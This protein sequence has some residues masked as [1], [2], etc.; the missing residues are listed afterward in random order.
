MWSIVR[1][2]VCYL[3]KYLSP[4]LNRF[5]DIRVRK[6]SVE[7]TVSYFQSQEVMDV[8]KRPYLETRAYFGLAPFLIKYI[9]HFIFW[10]ILA[11]NVVPE[12]FRYTFIFWFHDRKCFFRDVQFIAVPSL[13]HFANIQFV[14][15]HSQPAAAIMRVMANSPHLLY[16][17]N[18]G[19]VS[20]HSFR[21]RWNFQL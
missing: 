9:W 20:T 5:W 3:F 17:T 16:H 8:L 12:C 15:W 21:R 6:G 10:A 13:F 7:M 11:P 18:V 4:H 19:R 2:I 1:I 14:N